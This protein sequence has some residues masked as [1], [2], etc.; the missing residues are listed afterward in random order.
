M[1]RQTTE[2]RMGRDGT[3]AV[4]VVE[5]AFEVGGEMEGNSVL[6]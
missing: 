5:E 2:T 6:L 4:A 3:P 1:A